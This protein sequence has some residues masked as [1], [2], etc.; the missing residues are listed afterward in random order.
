MG[1]EAPFETES[2]LREGQLCPTSCPGSSVASKADTEGTLLSLVKEA[3]DCSL[4]LG[5]YSVSK[6]YVERTGPQKR[7]MK[8]LNGS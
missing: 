2:T 3:W 4:L 1:P 6:K 7:K 8:H 5:V